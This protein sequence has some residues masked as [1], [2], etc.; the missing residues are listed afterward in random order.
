MNCSMMCK[1][2]F[3]LFG[4]FLFTGFLSGI[5]ARGAEEGTVKKGDILVIYDGGAGERG[6]EQAED[7]VELLTYQSFRVSYVPVS[8]SVEAMDGFSY[9]ICYDLTRYPEDF[10]DSLKQ[11]ENAHAG[12]GKGESHHLL[13]VGSKCLKAY[14]DDTGRSGDYETAGSSTGKLQY[15]FDGLD[16]W[17]GIV[18]EDS[19]IFFKGSSYRSGTIA[20]NDKQGYYC[21]RE[22]SITHIPVTDISSGLPRAALI[23][24][25]AQWKWPYKGGPNIFAQ[26]I[27]IHKVYPYEDPDKLLEVVKLLV[28][29]RTPFVISVM[30][31]Y[32]NGDYPAMEH[33]CEILRYAQANGGA[34]I[35]NAPINQMASFDKT[36]VMD[37]LAQ[38]L[39]V[40]N[41]HGVYPLALEVPRNWMFNQGA[42]EI[43][44]HFKTIFTS[45]EKDPYI[46]RSGMTEN[47]VY[48]DGHQW[49][50]TAAALD[51][52]GTSYVSAYSSAVPISLETD[53]ED[54]RKMIQACKTSSIPLK[55]LWDMEH[56]YWTEK[57]LM[58]YKNQNLMLDGKKMNLGFIPSTYEEK[59][60]YHRNM[61]QR[62]SRDLT[63]QN[64]KLIGAVGV[65]SVLFLFF[66]FLARYRNRR[67]Y[68]LSEG[69]N[70]K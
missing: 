57:T 10:L 24:E 1:R 44:S 25:T 26:Y 68:F 37:Y 35:I 17:A 46:K 8:E 58:T 66:I 63:S 45:G 30:P 12:R 11:Y 39:K 23:K 29:D 48:K 47:L 40:Y 59:Y 3:F 27:V 14:L 18:K 41:K 7:V 4:L 13:F 64:R 5:S 42:V 36:V 32:V 61:L 28:N 16:S 67:N 38:A 55:S 70:K 19:F 20:V 56:S 21:A 31:I 65:T 53:M 54:I 9:I 52:M 51:H 34:V 49:A 43:M 33:F 60:N 62:F 2:F 15:S 6:L 50:G 22:G 69:E